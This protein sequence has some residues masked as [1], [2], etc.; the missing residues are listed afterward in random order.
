MANSYLKSLYIPNIIRNVSAKNNEAGY[1]YQNLRDKA[2]VKLIGDELSIWVNNVKVISFNESGVV[3]EIGNGTFLPDQSNHSGEY[4]TTDGSVASWASVESSFLPDQS[5]HNGKYLK[6]DGS[7]ASW[8]GISH[9]EL[10]NIGNNTHGQIDSHITTTNSHISN[11]SNP[12]SVTK[13]QIGLSNI[14]NVDNT[15][16]DNISSGTL[17]AARLA[18]SGVSPGSYTSADVTVD[19]YGRV[20]AISSNVFTNFRRGKESLTS[21]S[22][23]ISYSSSLAST[24]YV[25]KLFV[26]DSSG[27]WMA[28]QIT[29]RTTDG[30]SITVPASGTVDY[31]AELI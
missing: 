22:N 13:T 6:T 18:S 25:L 8:S 20:T 12:H 2:I 29:S 15:N 9:T 30:F 19:I 23:G 11:T 21:G 27:N 14:Q 5:G 24:N 16:A 17:G 31:E 28:H 26:Y 3:D 4:L 1:I 7:D 10:Q